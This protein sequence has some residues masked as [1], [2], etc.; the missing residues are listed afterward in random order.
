MDLQEIVAIGWP[1]H[2]YV[3]D[4]HGYNSLDSAI[5]DYCSFSKFNVYEDQKLVISYN[6][7]RDAI[8]NGWRIT[9]IGN[10]ERIPL[11]GD[12]RIKC[13]VY[14]LDLPDQIKGDLT[15]IE[16]EQSKALAKEQ[17]NEKYG[18]EEINKCINVGDIALVRHF[19]SIWRLC[20]LVEFRSN[21]PSD[22]RLF[23]FQ[24]LEENPQRFVVYDENSPYSNTENVRDATIIKVEKN[25]ELIEKIKKEF[26][27]N[28]NSN[29][30]ELGLSFLKKA[31][32]LSSEELEFDLVDEGD[33]I[34]RKGF[35][36]VFEII[37]VDYHQD[38]QKVWG[39]SSVTFLEINV[40]PREEF[41]DEWEENVKFCPLNTSPPF[42]WS[43]FFVKYHDLDVETLY[44]ASDIN[45]FLKIK[46]SKQIKRCRKIL[47]LFKEGELAFDD[48]ND[49]VARA[50]HEKANN[51]YTKLQEELAV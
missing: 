14:E 41:E 42:C 15:I 25:F 31:E 38:P 47:E 2:V 39:T 27:R 6:A 12:L 22:E 11:E 16:D 32:L 43:L 1:N 4:A 26:F 49:R 19:A 40:S 9:H 34:Y 21:Y 37:K 8:K 10:T 24:T 36:E 30:G 18:T 46:N 7:L 44:P 5:N 45:R 20:L 17:L 33:F 13:R 35:P 50:L 23:F 51:K 48:A 3:N 29:L 28:I